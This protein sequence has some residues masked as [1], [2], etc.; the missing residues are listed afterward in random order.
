MSD[1]QHNKYQKA[2]SERQ[3]H[4][5]YI[6]VSKA[7]KK[8]VVAGPGTGKTYLFK[9]LLEG[10]TNTLTLTFI[11]SLV[12]DLSLELCG[13]SDV[14]TLHGFARS[15]LK[16]TAGRDV[17]VFPKL[18]EV[19]KE[20]AKILL[21]KDVDFNRLFHT[22]EDEN[23]YV[24]FYKR[25]KDYYDHYGYADIVFAIVKY[26]ESKRE[27]IPTY[28]QIVV[29]EF[30]DFNKLEVSLIEL[31]AERS[32][33][34]L[35]GDDDQA[36]YDFK[37]A[38]PEHIRIKHGGKESEYAGFTLPYCSRCTRVIVEAANDVIHNAMET[39]YLKGRLDKPYKYFEEE[40]KDRES[41]QY[42]KLIYGKLFAKQI[43][44]FIEKQLC[45]IAKQVKGQFSVLVIS[46]TKVGSH[47]VVTALKGK[48]LIGVESIE[49][50][51]GNE[52]TLLDG[53]KLLLVDGDCN[54]GW[55]IAAKPLLKKREEFEDLVTRSNADDAKDI[56]KI[57]G[58]DAKQEISDMVRTLKA[59]RDGK[60]VDDGQLDQVFASVGIVPREIATNHL[61]EE[62]MS[63]TQRGGNPSIRKIPIKAT[64]IQSSKGLAAE[65]VFIT[66]FDD[67]YFVKNKDKTKI[68]DQDIC[69]FLV[70][71]T[72][73]KRKVFLISSDMKKE[74]T[75]LRWIDKGRI[76]RFE[77]K[78]KSGE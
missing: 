69:N 68:S 23:E 9:K 48:G 17:K 34:L 18:A 56:F 57:I 27:Q 55:R 61:R 63:T 47:G 67:M 32:P 76:E 60:P 62:I 72:R 43:P 66:H 25:R 6:L 54:L 8:I 41:E 77:F 70:A 28:E 44:W 35:A 5:D 49:T 46:P 3:K 73:A 39:G 38:S 31:L 58:D 16:R 33:I 14:K 20:D 4:V 75:F 65:Y 52:P 42:P 50:R 71:L 36:L 64:T 29:D 53:L 2:I 24:Q 74:P 1:A 37:D 15:A 59:V 30:Q 78:A 21:D 11:N 7:N 26:F 13:M 10:K 19:I 40:K 22:R 12:E 51:G 45:E